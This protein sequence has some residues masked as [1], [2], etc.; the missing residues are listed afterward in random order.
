M[1]CWASFSWRQVSQDF[2]LGFK[3][4][5]GVGF[6]FRAQDFRLGFRGLGKVEGLS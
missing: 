4:F 1:T 5:R 2:R 6:G 3:E